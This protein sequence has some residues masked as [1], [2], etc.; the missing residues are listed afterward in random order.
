M[1]PTLDFNRELLF[2]SAFESGNLDCV[3]QYKPLKYDCF[4]RIDSNTRGHTQWYYFRVKNGSV[5]NKIRIN[6]CNISKYCN[7]YEQG[8]EPFCF[9][10]K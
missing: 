2:D 1:N 6:L 8:L 4:L 9:S 10:K 3:I 7:L 5:M